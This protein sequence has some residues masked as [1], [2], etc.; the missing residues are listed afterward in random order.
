MKKLLF[1]FCNYNC[2]LKVNLRCDEG[3][4]EYPTC[5]QCNGRQ[6]RELSQSRPL[7]RAL[8]MEAQSSS[9]G[10]CRGHKRG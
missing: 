9:S 8:H 7:I 10:T 2:V 1:Y 6:T 5:P 3:K 4:I